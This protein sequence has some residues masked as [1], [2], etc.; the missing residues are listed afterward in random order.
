MTRRLPAVLSPDDFPP[1]ELTG[2]VLDGDAYRLDSCVAPI[3]E[4]PEPV[5]RARALAAELMPRLIVEQ[6]TAAWIW[7]ALTTA[8]SVL[9]VCSDST[10]RVRPPLGTRLCVREVVIQ[11]EDVANLGGI[12]VTTPLRTAID[13][14]RFVVEWSPADELAVAELMRFGGF[15]AIDCARVMNRRRNLPNKRVALMRLAASQVVADGG[16]A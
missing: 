5:L 14:A 8:P 12:T 6:H 7:G 11:H 15:T 4:I 3:D 13:L 1:A 2:I 16:V 10:A 9:E